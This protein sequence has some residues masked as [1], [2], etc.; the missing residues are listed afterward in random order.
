MKE[1]RVS[2]S[3]SLSLTHTEDGDLSYPLFPAFEEEIE[4]KFDLKWATYVHSLYITV[5]NQ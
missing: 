5:L 1:W 3:L 4:A 2:L